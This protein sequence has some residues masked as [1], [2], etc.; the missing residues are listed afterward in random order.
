MESRTIINEIVDELDTEELDQLIELAT[1]KRKAETYTK[2]TIDDLTADIAK[3]E[4]EVKIIT[5]QLEIDTAKEIEI[6]S[7]V[8]TCEE[9]TAKYERNQKKYTDEI[10]S[11]FNQS[12]KALVEHQKELTALKLEAQR[13]GKFSVSGK[14]VPYDKAEL[15]ANSC[16]TCDVCVK[17]IA[18]F[19]VQI[20]TL[21]TKV[22]EQYVI[23]AKAEFFKSLIAG[24]SVSD[25]AYTEL[26]KIRSRT[27][28]S[29]LDIV[30]LRA[31]IDGL[32]SELKDVTMRSAGKKAKC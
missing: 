2:Q 1:A 29:K 7:K 11:R 12:R 24:H 31:K 23:F 21:T 3:T 13:Y 22:K 28:N 17:K 32:K 18:S 6:I 10:N 16:N 25:F 19:N 15:P 27:L 5:K 8:R 4:D 9:E 26:R 14:C 20:S 30:D